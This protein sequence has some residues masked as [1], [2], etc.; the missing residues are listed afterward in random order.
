MITTKDFE[1]YSEFTVV[2][3][4]SVQKELSEHF[5]DTDE[6]DLAF[7]MWVPCMG[8]RRFT[9]VI[10]K[11]VFPEEGDRN[12]HHNASFNAKYVHRIIRMLDRTKKCGIVFMHSHLT[13]GWQGMSYDDVRAEHVVLAGSMSGIT[14]LPLVGM[15]RGTDGSWSARFWLKKG[16]KKFERRWARNVRVAGTHLATTYHPDMLCDGNRNPKLIETRSVW[17]EANQKLIENMHVGIVGLGSVG[18]IVAECLGRI[19]VSR[20]TLIDPDIIKTRNL[21]R[22]LGA[23]A[24]D[25]QEKRPK[26]D[27]ARRMIKNTHTSERIEI[28]VLQES[29][30]SAESVRRIL[31]C[32]VIFSC[33]DRPWPRHVLNS[34]SYACLIPVV[35][36]GIIAKVDDGGK[37]VHADWRIHTV[38]PE[39]A[40]LVCLNALSMGDVALDRAGNLDD[41]EYIRSMDEKSRQAVSRHNVFA[42]SMSVAAHE[43]IQFAGLVTGI[44]RIGGIGPQ[45]YHAYPG[46]ME[47]VKHSRCMPD[48]EYNKLT[49]S[50][51]IDFANRSHR[52]DPIP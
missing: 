26:V 23:T 35:D 52:G 42:F 38:G 9:A 45:F 47:V 39:K 28:D 43:V 17:G 27:V 33:V 50:A 29:I 10:Q 12:R 21:D 37:L 13:P 25:A 19:G 14:G 44:S 41:P 18:S 16:T 34:I 2:L 31:D 24:E 40:C 30:D 8:R 36:G 32:D 48:C 3:T 11:I 1:A 15:T 22:T 5:K 6:E 49:A 46:K 7:G 4:G 51:T 20:I